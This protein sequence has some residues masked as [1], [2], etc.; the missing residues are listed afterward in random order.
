MKNEDLPNDESE[1]AFT[2]SKNANATGLM[3]AG[4]EM[5]VARMKI[6]LEH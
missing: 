6:N 5:L 1:T 4:A 3:S 2:T